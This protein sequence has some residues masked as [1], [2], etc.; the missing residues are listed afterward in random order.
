VGEYRPTLYEKKERGKKE[1]K[2]R[3]EYAKKEKER[4]IEN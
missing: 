1:K 3:G 4:S 2:K